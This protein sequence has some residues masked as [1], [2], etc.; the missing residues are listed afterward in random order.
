MKFFL[1]SSL[2]FAIMIIMTGCGD[3]DTS[4]GPGTLTYTYSEF[5]HFDSTEYRLVKR[6]VN[7]IF[8]KIPEPLVNYEKS[9]GEPF[10][11]MNGNGIYEAGIDS[12]T[13]S[14]NPALNQDLNGNGRYDS[15]N[16][17]WTE[18][19]P[20]DDIDGNGEYRPYPGDNISGYE[21]G[22][23]YADFNDNNRHDGDLKAAYGIAYWNVGFLFGAPKYTLK[24]Y[25]DAVYRFVSDSGLS[26]DLR[27][28]DA[29]TVNSMVYTDTSLDYRVFAPDSNVSLSVRLLNGGVIEEE[30][31]TEII[32]PWYPNP[33]IY[34]RWVT[35]DKTL[36]VDG[37][38]LSGLIMVRLENDDYRYDFYFSRQ[39]GLVA[40]EIWVDKSQPPDNWVSYTKNIEYYF[41][42]YDGDHPMVFPMTR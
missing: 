1:F 19:I 6:D 39:Y 2:I 7:D 28:A 23:P 40:Y 26:Y 42:R 4:T 24:Y 21:A 15:P 37:I 38:N 12:F 32:I 14:T 31:S 29:P 10:T 5:V 41:K 27:M 16:D 8:R 30:D 35:R 11:D 36:T 34:Y 22:L 9:L 17:P 33:V 13:I 20:F 18:G 3:D 25:E